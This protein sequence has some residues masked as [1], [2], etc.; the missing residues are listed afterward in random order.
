MPVPVPYTSIHYPTLLVT[1]PRTPTDVYGRSTDDRERFRGRVD[2]H[3]R[4]RRMMST[5]VHGHPRTR[6]GP[7]KLPQ[8][9]PNLS[10]GSVHPL[11]AGLGRLAR[12]RIYDRLSSLRSISS[13][14]ML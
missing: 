3:R 9:T 14:A 2:A 10:T 7:E 8:Q 6:L 13:V 4:V 1:R 5:D 11:S 12:L